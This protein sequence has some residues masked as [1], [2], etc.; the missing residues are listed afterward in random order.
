ME[1]KRSITLLA[2]AALLGSVAV[3]GAANAQDA[4]SKAERGKQLYYVQGCYA[5]HGYTG[6]TG[7]AP[8]LV[9]TGS[10]NIASESNFLTFL[11]E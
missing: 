8:R 2:T 1:R 9:G 5:C 7:R 4:P 3:M 11:R 6:E 10:P